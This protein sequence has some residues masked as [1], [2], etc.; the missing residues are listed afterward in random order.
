MRYLLYSETF[1]HRQPESVRQTGIGRYCADLASGLS[2]LGQEVVVLTNDQVGGKHSAI[3]EPYQIEVLGAVPWTRLARRARRRQVHA[4]AT[5]LSADF[6]LVGDPL[7]HRVMARWTGSP[8]PR[9]C[10]IFHG[11]ELAAWGRMLRNGARSPRAALSAVVLRRYV[12]AAHTPV[13]NSRFTRRLLHEFLPDGSR[14]CIVCP[15]VSERVLRQPVSASSRDA[16]R[17]RLGSPEWPGTVLLTVGRISDRKNQL[18]VVEVLERLTRSEAG[19]FHYVIVG[20][21][22]AG[23]HRAYRHL[24]E[25]RIATA[26][27]SGSVTFI[28]GATDEEKIAYIDACDIFVML[29]Q[30]VGDSVEGFGI[31]A[32]EA[33][34]R[35]KPVVVSD[36]GGMPETVIDESTGFVVAPGDV[37]RLTEVLAS[38]AR[39]ERRR[40]QMGQAGRRFVLDNFTPHITASHLHERL[41]ADPALDRRQPAPAQ[42]RSG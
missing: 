12:R 5:A 4:R 41:T 28:E 37:D 40:H 30:I 34:C 27:L 17:R 38:L 7:G 32:I 33:A 25:E 10:P 1:P 31:S 3:P 35:G 18:G 8:F 19:S 39:D 22:D 13:C 26:G 20:N 42:A 11:T 21:T 2:E 15:S 16:L 9:L 24:L 23:E 14:E 6:L 36:Q 29:S